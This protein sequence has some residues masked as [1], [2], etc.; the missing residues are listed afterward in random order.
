M[1]K[2]EFLSELKEALEHNMD[3]QK[4]K[5]HVEYYD[6]YILHDKNVLPLMPVVE[7][8]HKRNCEVSLLLPVPLLKL[9]ANISNKRI[10][11]HFFGSSF[12]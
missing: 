11:I 6:E 2:H 8:S 3:E 5:G 1:K 7:V 9:P 12:E 10:Q 4:I